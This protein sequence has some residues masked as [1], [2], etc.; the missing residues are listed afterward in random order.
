MNIRSKLTLQFMTVAAG[1]M[2]LTLSFIYYRFEHQLLEEFYQGLRSKA[3]MSAEMLLRNIPNGETLISKPATPSHLPVRENIVIFDRSLDQIYALN[4]PEKAI[5]QHWLVQATQQEEVRWIE[6][7]FHFLGLRYTTADDR[8]Y[9]LVTSAIFDTTELLGLQR[10]LLMAFALMILLIAI[11]GWIF[12]GQALAPVTSVMNEV[13]AILPTNLNQRIK[14]SGGKDEISRL[15]NTFNRMLDRIERSFHLQKSFLSNVSHELKNPLSIIFSQ[16]EISLQKER[17]REEYRDTL[18][19]V[20]EDMSDLN[21]TVDRLMQLAK[22]TA[23]ETSIPL[24]PLYIDELLWQLKTGFDNK[25]PTY[26]ME[27][28]MNAL[29]ED[30]DDL[31]VW[32]NEPLLRMALQNIA[33]NGC[34]YS[35]EGKVK[36]SLFATEEQKI[37]LEISDRGRGIASTD[38]PHIFRPFYRGKETEQLKKGTGVGLALVKSILQLHGIQ[39]EIDSKT[40]KGT[41]FSLLFPVKKEVHPPVLQ[42][43]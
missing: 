9:I 39:F 33:E 24:K 41:V 7:P 28:Q 13:D 19:S 34:K 29:P 21:E 38:L 10:I 17:S 18:T 12:A 14:T 16:L 31:L 35:D 36:L 6:S 23:D 15:T 5:D 8:Q 30:H 11:G 4:A 20:L 37:R 2:V 22:L 42:T 40:G 25:F 1:L 27:V 26:K 32:G 3:L 43:F